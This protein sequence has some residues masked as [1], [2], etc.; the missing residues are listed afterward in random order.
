M[1]SIMQRVGRY[2]VIRELGR[3]AM[4]VV[5]EA[6]DPLIDRRVAI[7]TIP[8]EGV[9]DPGSETLQPAAALESALREARTAGSLSH[10]GI[11]VVHDVGYDNDVVF[12][13]M[14]NVEG[15]TLRQLM[16]R[17]PRM[18][19]GEALNILGQ[20]AAA[21]DFAHRQGVVHQCQPKAHRSL[22]RSTG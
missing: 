18:G 21:L 17:R 22:R 7:K 19:A 16:A 9:E 8:V 20:A 12:I 5:V 1:R 10:H 15:P 6:M 4:G 11:V 14:E 2:E 13:A 3:G